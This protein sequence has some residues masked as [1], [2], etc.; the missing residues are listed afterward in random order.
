MGHI[1]ADDLSVPAGQ[2][3]CQKAVEA[4]TAAK[5]YDHLARLHR[6]DAEGIPAPQSEVGFFG[7][8]G[9]FLWGVADALA[10]GGAFSGGEDGVLFI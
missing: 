1:D 9:D 10:D 4:G 3:G 5:V 8:K 7:S 6:N 2:M